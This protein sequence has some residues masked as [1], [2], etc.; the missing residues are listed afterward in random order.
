MILKTTLTLIPIPGSQ[1]Y[2][3]LST[4]GST[5]TIKY[6][7][8]SFLRDFYHYPHQIHPMN[9]LQQGTIPTLIAC[10]LLHNLGV[11][12]RQKLLRLD[13]PPYWDVGYQRR[14]GLPRTE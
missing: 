9:A 7:K 1:V 10:S 2:Q 6:S 12:F 3:R 11:C 5:S 13:P 8:L 4:L 14:R